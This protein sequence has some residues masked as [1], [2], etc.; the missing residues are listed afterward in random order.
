AGPPPPDS[1]PR[2]RAATILHVTEIVHITAVAKHGAIEPMQVVAARFVGTH[3]RREELHHSPGP[4]RTR[5]GDEAAAL[6]Q[7]F[8]MLKS[9]RLQVQPVHV[10]CEWPAAE[11]LEVLRSDES[12]GQTRQIPGQ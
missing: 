1:P 5:L 9:E 2:T 6:D 8:V 10:G 3:R 7:R 12:P 11:I 4:A